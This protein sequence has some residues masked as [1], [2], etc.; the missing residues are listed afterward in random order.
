MNTERKTY[1]IVQT[2]ADEYGPGCLE[3]FVEG[4]TFG[5]GSAR[6]V[7]FEENNAAGLAR[8]L[9]EYPAARVLNVKL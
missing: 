2:P 7:G 9:A 5:G 4:E 1:I 8:L 6:S 3:I